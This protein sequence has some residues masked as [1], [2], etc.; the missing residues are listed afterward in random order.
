MRTKTHLIFDMDGTLVD[1]SEL[2][3]NTINYVRGEIGLEPMPKK[4]I[5]DAI[6]DTSLHAA[7]FFYGTPQ[8]EQRHIDLFHAYYLQHHHLQSRL[9]DGIAELLEKLSRTHRLSVATN[10]YEASAAPL[11]EA[12]GIAKH[13]DT[14]L[15]GDHVDRPKP[16]PQMI[17]KIVDFYGDVPPEK[18]VMIG[19]GE[20]DILAARAAG[21]DGLLVAW[22]FDTHAD[23]LPSAEALAARLGVSL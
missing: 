4:R 12:L 16:H 3:A 9:Y 8:F 17:E 7:Q 6:N 19:D 11:L 2:L 23:A 13:F 21:I 14:L 15:C 5:T 10:A 20:R 1:S 18:F 22:G